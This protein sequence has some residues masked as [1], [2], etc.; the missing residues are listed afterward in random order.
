MIAYLWELFNIHI[1]ITP[2]APYA[3]QTPHPPF[4]TLPGGRLVRGTDILL[5]F[6][7]FR[8]IILPGGRLVRGTDILQ[9]SVNVPTGTLHKKSIPE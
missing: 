8:S 2:P 9:S 4:G 3:T 6:A 5:T 7:N 1:M